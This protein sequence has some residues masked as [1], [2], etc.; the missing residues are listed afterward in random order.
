MPSKKTNKQIVEDYLVSIK[1]KGLSKGTMTTYK[2]IADNLPFSVMMAQKTLI[3]KLKE[4]YSN[5][6]TLQ[7]YLNMIILVRRFKDEPTDQLVKLRNG[8]KDEI[9]KSRIEKLDKLDDELPTLDYLRDKLEKLEKVRYIVNYLFINHGLRNKDLNMIYVDKLPE[10]SDDNLIAFANKS[11]TKAAIHINKYKTAKAHGRKRNNIMDKRF[12]KE[13]KAMDLK[14]GDPVVQRKNG[15]RMTKV[16]TLNDRLKTLSIDK[17]GQNKIFK[18]VIRNLLN[19]NN[20]EKLDQYSKDRGTGYETLLKSYN[21]KASG[22]S[23]IESV[24]DEE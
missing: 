4:L 19:N 13:L 15:E 10:E 23:D 11:K 16:S 17:L 8:L 6:N 22:S 3:K 9:K 7:L 2:N 20:F 18:I 14:D 24:E 21:L 1:E 5:P 12:I